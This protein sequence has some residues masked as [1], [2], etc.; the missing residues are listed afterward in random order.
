MKSGK[1]KII[2]SKNREIQV[3]LLHI[4][5]IDK[6]TKEKIVMKNA[7]VLLIIVVIVLVAWFVVPYYIALFNKDVKRIRTSATFASFIKAEQEIE[8]KTNQ[9]VGNSSEDANNATGEN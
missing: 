7:I 2:S 5:K 1:Q 6:T 8:K 9:S 4:L 3:F